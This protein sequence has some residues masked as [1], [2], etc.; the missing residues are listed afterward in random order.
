MASD[1]GSSETEKQLYRVPKAHMSVKVSVILEKVLVKNHV[2]INPIGSS[3]TNQRATTT[4]AAMTTKEENEHIF[5][6]II[7][8]ISLHVYQRSS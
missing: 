4:A 5:S 3:R 8:S 2:A 6:C 7:C 1:S